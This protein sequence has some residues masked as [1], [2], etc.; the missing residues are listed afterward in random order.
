MAI[1]AFPPVE[2][3][4]E[5]GLVAIGGDLEVQ[6]LLLAYKS[7]IFPWPIH[8]EHLTWFSPDPRAVLFFKD[9]KVP[10]SL[11]K[12]RRRSWATIKIDQNFEA[13]I[14]SCAEGMNRGKQRGTW[15]TERMIDGYIGLHKAG[16]AHSIE[17]YAEDKLVGGLYG[18]SI[19]GA[20]A[21][22]SMFYRR[23]NASKLC[24]WFLVEYLAQRGLTWMDCQQLTPLLKSFGAKE[25]SRTS[26][27]TLLTKAL[28]KKSNIF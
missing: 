16:H 15:I 2:E 1:S 8:A 26:F 21:G 4:D 10:D 24:L 23:A 12:E 19:G 5:Y 14:R 20:F 18:V 27:M 11:K 9:L 17:C 3:A 13:V 25:I 22:E 7:G 28:A 6:S